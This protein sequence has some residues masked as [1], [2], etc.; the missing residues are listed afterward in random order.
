MPELLAALV[1]D[2]DD[3]CRGRWWWARVPVLAWMLWVLGN[4][5]ADWQYVGIVGGIN[6]GI[7]ELG[8]VIFRPFGQFIEIAGGSLT[9][10]LA[11]VAAAAV[12][13]RQ[14]D[15]FGLA[16][17]WAWLATNLFSVATYVADARSQQLHL[18]SPGSGSQDEI[19][20]DW[21]FLLG[22]LGLLEWDGALAALLR[23]AAVVAALVGIGAGSWLAW[24][25]ATLPPVAPVI[26]P[27]VGPPPRASQLR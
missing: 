9:Q 16:F 17:C 3:W 1:R 12:L 6:L 21:N 27:P 14:R 8:H 19:I 2:A 20:H 23:L 5:L 4:H 18:V 10:C 11:P 26:T 22:Q 25:M 7:H 13:W 15:W 24:R